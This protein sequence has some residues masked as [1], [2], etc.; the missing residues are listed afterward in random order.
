M[1]NCID[2][3][4]EKLKD[5]NTRLTIPMRL[6]FKGDPEPPPGLFITTEQIETGRGK[7]KAVLMVASHCPFCG[8][9]YV[10]P[11]KEGMETGTAQTEEPL[12]AN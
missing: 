9:R 8:E 6:W 7:P 4:N 2:T 1:C 10:A 11:E 5:R 12:T 3:V